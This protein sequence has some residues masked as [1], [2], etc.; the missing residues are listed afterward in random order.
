MP[1]LT[2]EESKNHKCHH[3]GNTAHYIS[4]N[5]KVY[6]CSHRSSHCPGIVAKQK[7][8]REKTVTPEQLKLHMKRMSKIGNASPIRQT[9][10]Y[11]DRVGSNISDTRK[12]RGVAKGENNPNFGG[13]ITS[14]TEVRAK[15]CK[16][17]KDS[18]KMGKYERTQVHRDLLSANVTKTRMN[19]KFSV[20]SIEQ[21]LIDMLVKY[22]IDY[23]YQFLI[24]TKKYRTDGKLF[25]RHVYDFFIPSVNLI[26]EV[27]GEYWHGLPGEKDKDT[28]NSYIA[29]DQGYNIIRMSGEFVTTTP[30]SVI[31]DLIINNTSAFAVFGDF[32]D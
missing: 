5:T 9:Q 30:D 32:Y 29:N 24:Q 12:A 13:K 23:K 26:I 21:R 14:K 7:E 2:T 3:C 22:N 19:F 25:Y 17:K 16:P 15:M 18:S 27:D 11:K 6:R 4:Y 10:A 31:A 8:A 28:R 1:K 20:T